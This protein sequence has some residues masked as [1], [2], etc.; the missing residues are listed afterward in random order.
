LLVAGFQLLV[1]PKNL[2]ARAGVVLFD[3]VPPKRSLDGAPFR[4][5]Q[6]AKPLPY[7]TPYASELLLLL[8]KAGRDANLSAHWIRP[9]ACITT[10]SVITEM[11]VIARPVKPFQKNA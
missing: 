5:G 6:A 3:A 2:A 8:G 10:K 1:K 7:E 9:V 4:V 11:M